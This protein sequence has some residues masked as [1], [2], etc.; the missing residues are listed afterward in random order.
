MEFIASFLVEQKINYNVPYR[1]NLFIV[2]QFLIN[3]YKN[4]SAIF[5]LFIIKI[6]YNKIIY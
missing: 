6:I 4:N 3:F 5:I 1:N 2:M